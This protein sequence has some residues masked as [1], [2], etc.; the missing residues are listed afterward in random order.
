ML[1]TFSLSE[2]RNTLSWLA[3]TYDS[4]NFTEP[5]ILEATWIWVAGE[6]IKPY[7]CTL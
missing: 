6:I 3:T 1:E 7:N 5:V 4:E 2:D